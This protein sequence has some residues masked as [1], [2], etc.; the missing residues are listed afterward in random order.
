M[1]NPHNI[2]FGISAEG[3]KDFPYNPCREQL[4]VC[5]C[6]CVPWKRRRALARGCVYLQMV[7]ALFADSATNKPKVNQINRIFIMLPLLL[8]WV[9]P[10]VVWRSIGSRLVSAG[11]WERSLLCQLMKDNMKQ[12]KQHKYLHAIALYS[13]QITDSTCWTAFNL[14]SI[15]ILMKFLLNFD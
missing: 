7:L 13:P 3:P 8:S 1:E 6:F 11:R 12:H 14:L 5:V 9:Q 2:C 10:Q 15:V 4:C